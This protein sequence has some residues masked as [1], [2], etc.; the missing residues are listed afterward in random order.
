MLDKLKKRYATASGRTRWFWGLL[1]LLPVI[2]IGAVLFFRRQAVL[3][4]LSQLRLQLAKKN[5]LLL[6]AQTAADTARHSDA[7]D[8]HNAQAAQLKTEIASIEGQIS[9]AEKEH[10]AALEA[11]NQASSWTELE[12]LRQKGNGQ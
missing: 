7:I 5:Q 1:L 10:R 3:G 6:D 12:T 4:R 9:D 2:V 8:R 11:I